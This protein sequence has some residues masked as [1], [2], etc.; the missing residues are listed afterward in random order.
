MRGNSY[1]K[2]LCF[3]EKAKQFGVFAFNPGWQI[4]VHP[5]TQKLY[6]LA[7]NKWSLITS[8]TSSQV[9]WEWEILNLFFDTFNVAPGWIMGDMTPS[10]YDRTTGQWSGIMSWVLFS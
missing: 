3:V 10:Y 9:P 1:F 7:P 2:Q 8:G 5:W 4:Y 6:P